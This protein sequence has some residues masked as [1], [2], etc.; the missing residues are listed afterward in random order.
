[1]SEVA[2]VSGISLWDALGRVPDP[3]N[4]SGR[5][6]PLPGIL[7][8]TVAALLAGRQGLS[9]ISRWGRQCSSG[10]LRKLG[11]F[12]PR[13]PCHAT[14]HNV[15]KALEGGVLE[16]ALAEWTQSALPEEAVLAMDGKTLRGSRFGEYPAVHLLAAYCD[17]VAGVVGQMP[18]ETDKTNEISVAAKLLKEVPMKGCV[19]TDDAMFAQKSVCEAVIAGGGDYLVSVKENQPGLCEAID[20]AFSPAFSPLGRA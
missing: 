15:F 5:R 8:L 19:V 1:M 14:Y 20:A 7:A 3:R 9:A 11:I 6:F 4:P 10:Q 18:V 13:S 12:R 17:A 16:K 2:E